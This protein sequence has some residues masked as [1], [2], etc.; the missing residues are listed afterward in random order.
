MCQRVHRTGI[1]RFLYFWLKAAK[2][3]L[4]KRCKAAAKQEVDNTQYPMAMK[5]LSAHVLRGA[6]ATKVNV[7]KGS[8][9]AKE[10]EKAKKNR[11]SGSAVFDD[12]GHF[13]T[14]LKKQSCIPLCNFC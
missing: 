4:A 8:T 6:C 2:P 13:E 12:F 1:L 11:H 10:P 5:L 3:Q 9:R 7:V 14:T